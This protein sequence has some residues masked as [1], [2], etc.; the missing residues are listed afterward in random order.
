MA[1][2]HTQGAASALALLDAASDPERTKDAIARIEEREVSARE[3]AKNARAEI[4]EL[5]TMRKDL[6]S[7]AKA[8]K[9][10]QSKSEEEL[11]A[12]QAAVEKLEESIKRRDITLKNDRAT[13]RTEQATHKQTSR[14]EMDRLKNLEISLSGREKGLKKEQTKLQEQAVNLQG[15]M[16][17]ANLVKADYEA[18]AAKLTAALVD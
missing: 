5:Q 17:A 7:H 6:D 13:L 2:L 12:R 10:A 9:A 4:T 8:M 11:V 16:A 1:A 3:A 18:K 14:I 15:A